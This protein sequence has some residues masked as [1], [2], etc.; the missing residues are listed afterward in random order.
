MLADEPGLQRLHNLRVEL[1]P[2]VRVQFSNRRILGDPLPIGAVR[3]H[4]IEGVAH[5]EDPGTDVDLLP[6]DPVR[7]PPAVQ[8]FVV[9]QEDGEVG[10]VDREVAEDPGPDLHVGLHRLHLS[11]GEGSWLQQ[12]VVAHGDLA[13]VVDARDGADGEGLILR[14]AQEARN[15]IAHLGDPP[16]VLAGHVIP[17]VQEVG[18]GGEHLIRL[19]PQPGVCLIPHL[20]HEQ[21]RDEHNRRKGMEL[22]EQRH[23]HGQRNQGK[24]DHDRIAETPQ[25]HT[26]DR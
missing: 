14:K 21:G 7:I 3:G 12:D 11:R 17:L 10:P 5:R 16:G 15:L 22:P 20:R 8:P 23:G 25:E 26:Q 24:V 13:D 2:R 19:R 18:E 9:L 6:A 1:G 4:G